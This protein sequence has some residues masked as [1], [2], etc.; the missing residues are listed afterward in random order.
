MDWLSSFPRLQIPTFFRVSC[1]PSAK[2]GGTYLEKPI[3]M[4]LFL[5]ERNKVLAAAEVGL[6]SVTHKEE[7]RASNGMVMPS[8]KLANDGQ[9]AASA[10][11]TRAQEHALLNKL[12]GDD[13]L[14]RFQGDLGI[15]GSLTQK[16]PRKRW[17]FGVGGVFHPF[18]SPSS[19]RPFFPRCR[20]ASW[21]PRSLR[22]IPRWRRSRK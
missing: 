14:R 20:P 15:L 7:V 9:V 13:G 8:G 5:Q 18:G 12:L 11:R 6:V 4:G 22:S 2:K 17:V 10:H 1:R 16:R 21:R 3:T 19:F